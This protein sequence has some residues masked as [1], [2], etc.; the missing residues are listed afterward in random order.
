MRPGQFVLR[1]YVIP[2]LEVD[3]R[4]GVIFEENYLQAVG[5]GV[6][7]VIHFGR[8][9]VRRFLLGGGGL[10]EQRGGHS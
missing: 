7:R 5:Q 3:D 2:D 6:D 8:H 9:D 4:H 1:P 10:I